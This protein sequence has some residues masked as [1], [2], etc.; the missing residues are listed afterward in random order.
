MGRGGKTG[1][2]FLVEADGSGIEG[3]IL[4]TKRRTTPRNVPKRAVVSA[5]GEGRPGYEWMMP[6]HKIVAL[7]VDAHQHQGDNPVFM[8]A[9]VEPDAFA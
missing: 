4:G 6:A 8:N 3:V 5:V 1:K 7:L 2:A 9:G